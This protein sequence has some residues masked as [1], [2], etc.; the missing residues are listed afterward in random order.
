V[1]RWRRDPATPPLVRQE[2]TLR[3]DPR[4][5]AAERTFA[6]L[7][8]FLAYCARLPEEPRRL[9]RRLRTLHAFPLELAAQEGSS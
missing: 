3:A 2:Q 6:T 5:A 4:F 1:R 8:G 9:W 7:P